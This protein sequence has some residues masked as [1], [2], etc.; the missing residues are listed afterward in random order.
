MTISKVKIK[1]QKKEIDRLIIEGQNGNVQARNK[2]I[3]LHLNL[4]EYICKDED[5]VQIA[6]ERVLKYFNSY[7]VEIQD[8]KNWIAV[9]SKNVKINY[10][11]DDFKQSNRFPTF[12]D[13]IF[14]SGQ[15]FDTDYYAQTEAPTFQEQ[16]EQDYKMEVIKKIADQKLKPSQKT[17]FNL[18]YF[19]GLLHQEIADF[20]SI[21]I[22]TSKSQLFRAKERI[23]EVYKTL[24]H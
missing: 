19:E 7:K 14:Y 24:N 22:G 2:V 9:L 10:R 17:I 21:N 13:R 4:I 23:E 15:E 6:V 8:F 18:Y 12:T 11:M 1:T 20:L 16:N 5:M 3:E